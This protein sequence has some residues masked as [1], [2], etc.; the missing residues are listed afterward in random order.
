MYY[1][2]ARG[3]EVA[4]E[5]YFHDY[6]PVQ[7]VMFAFTQDTH[8]GGQPYNSLQFD[9]IEMNQPVD[10]KIFHMPAK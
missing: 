5:V 2:S 4:I 7:G 3:Q 1:H 10:I 9:T 8:Y 6:R